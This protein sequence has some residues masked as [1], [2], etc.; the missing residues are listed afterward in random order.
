MYLW[1]SNNNP[2]FAIAIDSVS[3]VDITELGYTG[4]PTGYMSDDTKEALR[5][6]IRMIDANPDFTPSKLLSAPVTGVTVRGINLWDEQTRTGYYN[7][8]GAWTENA[9]VVSSKNPIY[10]KGGASYGVSNTVQIYYSEFKRDGAFNGRSSIANKIHVLTVKPDTAYI[11][12]NA[13]TGIAINNLSFNADAS[14]TSYHK[15]V[16]PVRHIIPTDGL[17]TDGLPGYG[18]SAGDVSNG[19]ERDALGQ[20][21]YVQRVEAVNLGD[22]TWY[23]QTAADRWYATVG[24]MDVTGYAK[25]MVKRFVC[26]GLP[27]LENV[28]NSELPAVNLGISPYHN[29]GG[30]IY[31]RMVGASSTTFNSTIAGMKAYYALANPIRTPISLPDFGPFKTEPGGSM[32]FDNEPQ[33]KVPSVLEHLVKLDERL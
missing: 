28:V 14:D 20:W 33:M 32:V 30:M 5:D 15:Y 31:V 27:V 9:N 24:G 18:W 4:I 11:H 21:W 12:I 25:E 10:V 7:D 22:L 13:G 3:I 6:V 29:S 8:S 23:Y 17:P 19:I 1:S 26:A 2:D 16:E